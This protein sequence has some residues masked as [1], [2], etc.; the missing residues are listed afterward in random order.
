MGLRLDIQA[1]GGVVGA[2]EISHDCTRAQNRK[3]RREGVYGFLEFLSVGCL[4]G[5][6]LGHYAGI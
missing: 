1:V 5:F 6:E 2:N 3:L 4:Q